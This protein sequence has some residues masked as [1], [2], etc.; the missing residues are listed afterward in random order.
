MR[1]PCW[2]IFTRRCYDAQLALDLVGETFARAHARRARFRGQSEADAIAWIWAIARDALRDAL[3][4]GRAERRALSR[5]GIEP[6]QLTDEELVRIEQLAGLEDLRA[7]LSEALERLAPEQR[8][9]LRL[10]VVQELDYATV[11]SR[12]GVSQATARARVS[13]GLRSLTVALDGVEAG[14]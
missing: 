10:R 3:R 5:L 1:R 8:E 14:R 13:R 4:R 11:A 2:C 6:P 7:A 9:A 12:L